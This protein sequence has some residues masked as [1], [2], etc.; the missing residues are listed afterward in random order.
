MFVLELVVSLVVF[1]GIT[2]CSD[3][4]FQQLVESTRESPIKNVS[5][6]RWYGLG[7]GGGEMRGKR[8]H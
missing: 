2:Y 1:R 4:K 3:E 5:A 7:G 6:F 8:V